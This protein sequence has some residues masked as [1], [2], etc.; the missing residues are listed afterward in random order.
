MCLTRVFCL[1]L[2]I[3]S[4]SFFSCKYEEGPAIS[5]RSPEK[6]LQG[7]WE[8]S[9]FQVN[10]I[11]CTDVYVEKCG[12]S[13]GFGQDSYDQW[14]GSFLLNQCDSLQTIYGGYSF[15]ENSDHK[16]I[17]IQT[18]YYEIGSITNQ[19][20]Y[21]GPIG[22]PL[23]SEWKIFKLKYKEMKLVTNYNDSEYV[24]ELS[25]IWEY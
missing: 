5:F 22:F 1:L 11:D 14:D 17:A 24:I 21:F 16:R 4:I 6:R 18:Y 12:C 23:Y 25:K 3:T 20:I 10:G 2:L 19:Y 7:V 15:I 8:V 9:R 13:F